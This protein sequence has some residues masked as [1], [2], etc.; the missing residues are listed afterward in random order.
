V[1]LLGCD[2]DLLNSVEKT[3]EILISAAKKI[4]TTVLNSYFHR[5]QPQGVT[6]VVVIEESHIS[7]HNWPESGYSAIDVFTCGQTDPRECLSILEE[8][9]KATKVCYTM[10][11]RGKYVEN[12]ST[13]IDLETWCQLGKE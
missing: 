8:G 4:N 1:E 10:L 13:K 11:N 9:F 12:G 6:G 7:A 5:F 3:E 2:F